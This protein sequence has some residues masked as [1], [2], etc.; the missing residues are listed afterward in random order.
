MLP[1]MAHSGR[2]IGVLAIGCLLALGLTAAVSAPKIVLV[3]GDSVAAGYGIGPARAFP[4]LIQKE[5]DARGWNFKVV[6]AGQ[7]GD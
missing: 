2:I 1:T 5:I 4:A 3:L 7:S 6:N